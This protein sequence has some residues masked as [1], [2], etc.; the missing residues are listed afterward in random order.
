MC[1]QS[2]LILWKRSHQEHSRRKKC[3]VC[4]RSPHP[5]KDPEMEQCWIDPTCTQRKAAGE[6]SSEQRDSGPNP[7][8]QATCG[9]CRVVCVCFYPQHQD[10]RPESF[11]YLPWDPRIELLPEGFSIMANWSFIFIP[12]HHPH[13]WGPRAIRVVL[14]HSGLAKLPVGTRQFLCKNTSQLW[15]PDPPCWGAGK[16]HGRCTPSVTLTQMCQSVGLYALTSKA[17]TW[18]LVMS[19][20]LFGGDP[21]AFG[22]ISKAWGLPLCRALSVELPVSSDDRIQSLHRNLDFSLLS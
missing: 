12:I 11:P 19:W 22:A 1:H 3:L 2:W 5:S 16:G 13:C 4:P 10:L 14:R 21:E 9:G 20:A 17:Q 18:C 15:R 7:R 6:T 8:T